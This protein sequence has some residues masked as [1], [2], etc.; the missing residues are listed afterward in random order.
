MARLFVVRH[1][2]TFD[3]GDVI[4]RVGGRTDLPLSASGKAQAEKLAAHF[5]ETPFTAAMASTPWR[6]LIRLL[7][8][9]GVADCTSLTGSE[10]PGANDIEA[11]LRQMTFGPATYQR[12]PWIAVA[13]HFTNQPA[14]GTDAR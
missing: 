7:P 8:G 5:A 6:F 4:T 13:V 1:G 14:D 12:S 9:G 3:A 10:E 11:W 2:N